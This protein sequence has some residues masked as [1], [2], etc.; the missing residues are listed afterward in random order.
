MAIIIE[1]AVF[2]NLR[3]RNRRYTQREKANPPAGVQH[4]K[5]CKKRKNA[6]Q[7]AQR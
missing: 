3:K 4:L 6:R 5:V 2:V 1:S 7:K